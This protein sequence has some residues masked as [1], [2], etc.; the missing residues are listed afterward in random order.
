MVQEREPTSVE[1]EGSIMRTVRAIIEK[2]RDGKTLSHDDIQF[3]VRSIVQG[4]ATRAQAAAFLAF[5][6]SNGLCHEETASLT[7]AMAYSGDTLSWDCMEKVVDKHSTGGVGDK[8]SLVLAP[9]W[10]SLGV[11]Y[12]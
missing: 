1:V 5:V 6:F 9:L 4:S 2:K 3:M 11:R 7:M 10:R 8:V 12:P